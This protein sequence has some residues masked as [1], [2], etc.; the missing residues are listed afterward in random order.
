MPTPLNKE[1]FVCVDCE[2]TGL[3]IQNDSI[4]EIAAVRFTFEKKIKQLDSL[5]DPKCD[6]PEESIAIH[7]ITRDMTAG[8]PT[9][10]AVLPEILSFIGKDIIVGHGIG[11][12]IGIIDNTA[13]R[14]NIPCQITSNTVIDTLR[15]ARLYGNSPSNSLEMLRQHFNIEEMGAHRALNDV[16]VNIEVFKKLSSQYETA[17]KLLEILASPI[18]MKT[19]PLGKYKGRYFKD[20]PDNYLRWASRQNFDRDL[21]FSLR[22]ELKK[23]KKGGLFSQA[24]N[25]FSTL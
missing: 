16:M 8:K 24:S 23:R 12:D 6:I 18:P 13:K 25:P 4:I 5:I 1:I 10:D 14:N 15:L 3:D 9:I 11:F 19:M 20:I 21:L 7:H 22:L 2:T 17:K